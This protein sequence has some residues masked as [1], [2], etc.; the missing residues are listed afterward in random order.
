MDA[1]STVG[2]LRVYHALVPDATV[3]GGDLLV[4]GGG[5]GEPDV[6]ADPR[7]RSFNEIVG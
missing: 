1:I 7:R 2:L 6:T 3:V 4:G 5:N